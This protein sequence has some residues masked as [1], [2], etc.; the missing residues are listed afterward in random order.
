MLIMI[1]VAM[2]P[3]ESGSLLLSEKW[4]ESIQTNLWMLWQPSRLNQINSIQAMA[5]NES[6]SLSIRR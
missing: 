6:S 2:R 4:Y 5:S 1:Y 3:H